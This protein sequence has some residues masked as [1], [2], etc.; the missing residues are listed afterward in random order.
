MGVSPSQVAP[1]SKSV[2]LGPRVARTMKSEAALPIEFLGPAAI[3]QKERTKEG[4]R[5]L[6][7]SLGAHS[8]MAA[9]EGASGPNSSS[10][11]ALSRALL[12]QVTHG[13]L[14]LSSSDFHS[15]WHRGLKQHALHPV[16]EIG[17]LRPGYSSP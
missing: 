4:K 16:L 17:S 14:V 10:T 12:G 8:V 11:C 6:G 3:P 15:Q 5:S 9:C 2:A 7:K 13:H 1:L